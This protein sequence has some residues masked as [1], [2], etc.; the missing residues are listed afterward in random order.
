MAG[1]NA[2]HR[3]TRP[4]SWSPGPGPNQPQSRPVTWTDIKHFKPKEFT[5][6]C[7]GLC[8]H[9]NVISPAVV[10]KLD[11]IRESIGIPIAITSGTRCER[12]NRKV[13]G[14]PQSAHIPRKG[15]SYAVDVRCPD[16]S[17]RYTF[18]KAALP[19]FN[20]IG[21]GKDFVHVDDDPEKTRNIVW[22]Y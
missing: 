13:G 21:I 18:L 7:E 8:D 15:V 19:M 4:Q 14:K 17:F 16:S 22:V 5:C 20:R 11:K 6:N 2:K 1:H 3:K 12:H 10:A 9:P